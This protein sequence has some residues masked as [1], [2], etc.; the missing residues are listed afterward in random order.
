MYDNPRMTLTDLIESAE[1]APSKIVD[2]Y[3]V[4]VYVDTDPDWVGYD[5]W[6]DPKDEAGL[7]IFREF[8][9]KMVT[10]YKSLANTSGN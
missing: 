9:A 7:S 8:V 5:I 6:I 1:K 4:S 3:G 10:H 2:S